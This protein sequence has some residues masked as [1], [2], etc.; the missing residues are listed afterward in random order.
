[1]KSFDLR[2]L[3]PFREV[4]QGENREKYK[5]FHDFGRRPN[6]RKLD[7]NQ[8]SSNITAMAALFTIQGDLRYDIVRK[9]YE[10]GMGIVYEA[11]QH[12]ARQFVK[13]VAIKVIRQNYANQKQFIENFIGEAKLVAD[14]IHTNIVQTYQL[15]EAKDIYYIA[16]ELIRGVNL[17]QFSDQLLD[18]K[19]TLPLELAVFIASRV[20]R[21]LSYAH[22]KTDKD[23][24]PLGIV[25]RD[26]SF[27]NIMIAF[28][29]DVKLTDFGI[30]KA[31]GFLVDDE[32]EVVAG[33]ADFMSPE[34]ANFQ[35]TDKRSDLFSVGVVLAALLL[36]RNVFKGETPETSRK[37]VMTMPIPDFRRLDSRIDDR[38]NQILHRCFARELEKRY[39]L[40]DELL[41]DLEHY[42]YHSGYGPTNETLGKMMRELFGQNPSLASRDAK[43]STRMLE[44][45]ARTRR[46]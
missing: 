25:H 13:R 28:E 40:A 14:L 16:M 19:Q 41:Y 35:I 9:I 5:Y 15:G 38:L 34:Q 6:Q 12:G 10:G 23:G 44:R 29:G 8:G 3:K 1:M 4:V 2:V 32:G 39:P 45:T 30:A 43:G 7:L 17:E 24:K 36:G 37:N 33:K 21:G 27:K 46:L 31:R 11:E 20:V 22:A 26:V 18:K 42:I